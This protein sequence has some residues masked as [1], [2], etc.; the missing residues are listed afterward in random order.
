MWRSLTGYLPTKDNLICKRVAVLSLCPVCNIE[1][2]TVLHTLVTCQFARMCWNHA[3]I[4]VDDRDCTSF[5]QWLSLEMEV[6]TKQ[7]C[8]DSMYV[9]MLGD[10]E[11]HKCSSMAPKGRRVR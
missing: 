11:K 3:G 5:A 6:Y 9:I 7:R 8:S 1:S 4:V 10:M 2:E